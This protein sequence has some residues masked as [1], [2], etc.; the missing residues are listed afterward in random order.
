[1]GKLVQ[2]FVSKPL[3]INIVVVAVLI[4]GVQKAF[5]IKKEGFPSVALNKVIIS[6]IY[7]GASTL[8][9]ELNVTVP[10][11]EELE[12]VQGIDEI[13]S[14]S[15]EGVSTIT[16]VVDEDARP[17][18]FKI[19]YNE[20]ETAVNAVSDLPADLESKPSLQWIL[21]RP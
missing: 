16:I 6:T 10:L 5:N 9:V 11:E 12:S 19:I 1:M 18:E 7:P 13:K 8:D 21:P 3:F 14:I 15:R 20:I 4:L 17:E 2:F